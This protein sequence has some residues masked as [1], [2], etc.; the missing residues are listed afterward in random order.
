MALAARFTVDPNPRRVRAERPSR[1]STTTPAS[2]AR[3]TAPWPTTSTGARSS[4]RPR[5]GCSTTSTSWRRRSATSAS[6]LPRGYYRELPKLALRELAGH[7]RVYAMAVELIRHSDSRLD[8]Q[9]L[10]RFMNS[11]QRSRR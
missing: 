2:C 11:Y 5:S 10:V 4:P 3:P 6:N 8:R 9:Q 7:A 1:A